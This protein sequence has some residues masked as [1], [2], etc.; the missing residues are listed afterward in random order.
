[1]K[2][3]MKFWISAIVVLSMNVSS[4]Q[5]IDEERMKRDIKV[6]ENALATLIKHEMD[7]QRTLFGLDVKGSYQPGYGVTFRLPPEQSMP[8]VISMG[9][10]MQGGATVIH[11][12]GN[13]F[14]YSYRTTPPDPAVAGEDESIKLKDKAREKRNSDEDSVRASFDEKVITAAKNFILDYGD[15]ISQLSPQERIGV[16]NQ[17]DR[18]QFYLNQGKRSRISVEGVRADITS[19]RQGKI[20]RDQAIK[21]LTIVRTESVETREA[22]MEM[23]ASIFSRLYRPDLSKTYFVQGNVYYER[24][25]DYG[26]VFYMQMLSSNQTSLNRFQIPTLELGNLDEETRDRKVKELYPAFEQDV[27]ENILEYGRTV[28]SLK[29]EEILVF[30]ILLTKCVG[31]GIPSTLEFTIQGKTLKEY[32]SGKIQKS[33]AMSKFTVKRGANQ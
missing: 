8:F 18:P 32:G 23:L 31:C 30:N 22:D 6:A 15:I 20:S 4:A 3:I 1:M 12:G 24:L 16:T 28:K 9:D 11:D 21:K 5:T 2:T 19:Y 7:P 29:D 27:K 25:K 14:R 33:D 26:A 10:G 17:F 13:T